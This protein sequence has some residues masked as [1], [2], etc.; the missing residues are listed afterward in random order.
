MF[1]RTESDI[2]HIICKYIVSFL[3]EKTQ[4]KCERKNE[5]KTENK[6]GVL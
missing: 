1:K 2:T 4:F 3:H 6:R 5:E